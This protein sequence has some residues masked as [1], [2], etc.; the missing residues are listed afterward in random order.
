[1]GKKALKSGEREKKKSKGVSRIGKH[2]RLLG[3]IDRHNRHLVEIG[4]CVILGGESLIVLH[5]PIR[6]Y[7]KNNRVILD[8]YVW[9]GRRCVIL[10]GVHIG[11]FAIIGAMS[12]VCSDVDPYMIAAGN[13]CKHIRK[14]KPLEILRT[15]VI[16][17]ERKMLGEVQ[18][19]WSVLTIDDIKT[20]FSYKTNICYDSKL[21]LDN[22]SVDNVL[23]FYGIER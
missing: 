14:L 5:G 7:R 11:K 21:D 2:C 22:M 16:K 12:L 9:I 19:D 8:D 3:E 10:P 17:K 6:P 1:M 13:P 18:P 4:D 20:I 15:F 23:D